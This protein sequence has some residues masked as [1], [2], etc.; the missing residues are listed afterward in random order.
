MAP[1][2][3]VVSGTSASVNLQDITKLLA[4]LDA[5]PTVSKFESAVTKYP[6]AAV[7]WI[8]YLD[9]MSETVGADAKRRAALS[10][11]ATEHCPI[12]A[13]WERHLANV[14]A[15]QP[16][17]QLLPTYSDA[18]QAVGQDR[19]SGRLWME[20]GY[21]LK[22]LYNHQQKNAFALTRGD[23]SSEDV[24]EDPDKR[25]D[26]P[27]ELPVPDEPP[28]GISL[29]LVSEANLEQVSFQSSI[30]IIRQHYQD[31][32]STPSNFIDQLWDEY[33]EFEQA[34]HN[35][36]QK[37]EK[38]KPVAVGWEQ[39]HYGD[40][41]GPSLCSRLLTEYSNRYMSSKQVYKE[42]TRLYGQIIPLAVPVPLT[43]ESARKLR[44]NIKGWRQVLLYEKSNPLQLPQPECAEALRARVDLVF[45]QCLMG[46]AYVA[47]FWY[48]YFV[49]QYSYQ[50]QLLVRPT[51]SAPVETL[52]TAIN[53]YLP[54][55]VCLRLVLA[56]VLEEEQSNYGLR[57]TDDAGRQVDE[58]DQTYTDLLSVFDSIQQ[59][60][61][62]G[63]VHYLRYKCRTYGIEKCRE[64]FTQ[65]LTSKSR[66]M[67][68]EVIVDMARL[69]YRVVKNVAAAEYLLRMAL[70][71]YPEK[72][73][74]LIP[75]L[76]D[77]V[78]DVHG[79]GA[80]NELAAELGV[81]DSNYFNTRILPAPTPLKHRS[82]SSYLS[83]IRF[84]TLVPDGL[85]SGAGGISKKQLKEG[86]TD[87]T[88][89][90]DEIIDL[91]DGD[92][93]LDGEDAMDGR[94]GASKLLSQG[95]KRPDMSRLQVVKAYDPTAHRGEQQ[96]E[97]TGPTAGVADPN[98]MD[99][100]AEATKP[101]PPAPTIEDSVRI[102]TPKPVLGLMDLIP[103]GALPQLKTA[104]AAVQQAQFEAMLQRTGQQ[105]AQVPQTGTG[106]G[107]S[108][109]Q[110]TAQLLAAVQGAGAVERTIT[111]LSLP[112]VEQQLRYLQT[113]ELPK[114][115]VDNYREMQADKYMYDNR[116]ER[117]T[118][119]ES[120]GKSAT[121][122]LAGLLDLKRLT[123]NESGQDEE[124]QG[125]TLK[126]WAFDGKEQKDED[127]DV[128]IKEDQEALL[129]KSFLSAMPDNIH[130]ER[131]QYKRK[132]MLQMLNLGMLQP[133]QGQQKQQ[134]Q[135][136]QQQHTVE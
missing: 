88:A 22:M 89:A 5:R 120:T 99:L 41:V 60:C 100:R 66:H 13:I 95:I 96:N 11:R 130:R 94:A 124:L 18:L 98:D 85:R 81:F 109:Q 55:D 132:K 84:R 103:E 111:A 7:F 79:V 73:S 58:A 33:Q 21:L 102:D 36:E 104:E 19:D 23:T 59:S 2:S 14:K 133:Q 127:D 29:A 12:V 80:R 49:W 118:R 129:A 110:A 61:P 9:Y 54:Y 57:K 46:N 1:S 126:R 71:R 37:D 68:A 42:L 34:I 28:P 47:E 75:I 90:G 131:L 35:H 30:D 20:Y 44:R 122:T 10:V 128:I 56:M 107:G 105:L 78:A 76:E 48:D 62:T 67:S 63:L 119:G 92:A 39:G 112:D 117:L 101:D 26:T 87:P 69:E 91:D 53:K 116:M 106:G 113:L 17:A 115:N 134:Q 4:S 114:I 52:R 136:Q 108:S 74:M 82:Y 50:L 31:A 93:S 38:K 27:L 40:G 6:S 121:A 45:R 72:R 64:L 125:L 32:V 43:S 24:S 51:E 77:F 135:Q 25:G 83:S 15:A 65:Q 16:L 3:A 8:K 70:Q 97:D 86:T 123:G